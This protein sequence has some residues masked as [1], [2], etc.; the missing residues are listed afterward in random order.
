M[1]TGPEKEPGEGSR[2]GKLSVPRR[3]NLRSRE[4]GAPRFSA[5]EM[6]VWGVR[7]EQF[8]RSVIEQP[9]TVAATPMGRFNT[10]AQ[11]I[12]LSSTGQVSG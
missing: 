7:Y 4:R 2:P 6:E 3:A 1:R 5:R 9:G 8:Q 10:P 11:K 12:F